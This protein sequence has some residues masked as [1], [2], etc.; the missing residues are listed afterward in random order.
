MVVDWGA[1]D[2]L[3][4][5]IWCFV[6]LSNMPTGRNRFQFGGVTMGDDVYAVVEVA[7]YDEDPETT[8]KSDLLVPMVLETGDNVDG[9]QMR[10][11]YLT[12]TEAFV[13]PCC[14]IPDIG[15]DI[16]AYFQVSQASIRMV[17]RGCSLAGSSSSGR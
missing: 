1:H 8:T 4:S 7:E 11:F 3:P 2:H 12:S 10:Q 16:N 14:V 17:E 15:G 6:C 9:Q 5:R 13:G